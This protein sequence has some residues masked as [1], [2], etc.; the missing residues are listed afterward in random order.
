VCRASPR[1][2]RHGSNC[3]SS[4]KLT[5]QAALQQKAEQV[6]LAK[7][8]LEAKKAQELEA[9]QRA[10]RLASLSEQSQLIEALRQRC[11]DW[12]SKMPPNGNFKRQEANIAKAGLFQDASKLVATASVSA[13]WSAS[14][15]TALA[16]MLEQWL[17]KVVAPW[18]KDEKK[19]LKITALRGQ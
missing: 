16:D 19:K 13:A 14:D 2:P 4:S 18:G 3:A 6:A 11:A 12:E 1:P 9:E 8:A 10:V 7:K 5:K 17:P 15:K